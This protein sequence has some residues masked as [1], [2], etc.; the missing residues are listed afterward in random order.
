MS[1]VVLPLIPFAFSIHPHPSHLFSGSCDDWIKPFALGV[2]REVKLK[3]YLTAPRPLAN[4]V[5]ISSSK[6]HFGGLGHGNWRNGAFSPFPFKVLVLCKVWEWPTETRVHSAES[7]LPART[8]KQHKR[9]SVLSPKRVF[10]PPPSS[11]SPF[12]NSYF[13]PILHLPSRP[14]PTPLPWSWYT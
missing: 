13:F 6:P 3:A 1:T 10:L 9:P 12:R 4:E 8:S 7:T 5:I 11:P 2:S 14:S